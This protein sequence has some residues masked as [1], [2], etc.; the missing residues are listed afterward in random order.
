MGPMPDEPRPPDD[1]LNALARRRTARRFDPNR[2]I[3]EATLRHALR[4]A[5]LAPSAYN[6]QPWRFL[7]V[8]SARN[9]RRLRDAAFGRPW[10]EQASAV[11][12]VLAYLHPDRTDLDAIVA[13][14]RRRGVLD[15]AAAEWRARAGHWFDRRSR[16]EWA[17]RT[18]V[19]AAA[20]LLVAAEG[21][22]LASALIEEFDDEAVRAGF[23]IP[24]DHVVGPLVA[25]GYA[26]GPPPVS[27]GRLP[28]DRLVFAEHFGQPWPVAE[29]AGPDRG[30]EGLIQSPSRTSESP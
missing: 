28:L 22:G 7:L 29:S 9:R 4:L 15:D 14:A 20:L 30:P 18:A 25:L 5:T 12:V 17:G 13:E 1:T 19:L 26:D 2:P 23:G 21:L 10:I 24:D 3:A 8:R 16:P 6:F 11:V 27:P